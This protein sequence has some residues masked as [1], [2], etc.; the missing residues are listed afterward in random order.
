MNR[1]LDVLSTLIVLVFLGWL[2]IPSSLFLRDISMTVTGR[3]VQYVREVPYGSVTAEWNAEITLIDGEE[4]ECSSGAWRIAH[5]QVVSGNTVTYDL[6][7]WADKCL[8]AGP[9]YYL[10][11]TRRVLLFGKVPMRQMRTITEVQGTRAQ[12]DI[13]TEPREQ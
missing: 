5:Y 4:F 12:A 11:T 10:T 2:F 8:E 6:G 7:A 3:T 1:F 9:P 13:N